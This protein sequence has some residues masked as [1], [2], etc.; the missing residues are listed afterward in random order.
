MRMRLVLAAVFAAT[1]AAAQVAAPAPSAPFSAERELERIKR[2][3][4]MTNPA[5]APAGPP[6]ASAAPTASAAPPASSP[7]S[8]AAPQPRP[9]ATP[10][11]TAQQERPA[12]LSAE[13]ERRIE[14]REAA[15]K[16]SLSGICTGCTGTVARKKVPAPRHPAQHDE[17]ES[18]VE[19][20]L[21]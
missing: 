3:L 15:A 10:S 14:K 13:S 18:S 20:N 19:E 8:S 17:E 4:G 1:S 5:P 16:R 7:V 11:G 12:W 6:G 9:V 21:D 2:E